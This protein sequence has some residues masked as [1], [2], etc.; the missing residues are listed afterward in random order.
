MELTHKI[1]SFF[2]LD[3]LRNT[4]KVVNYKERKK[5][6]SPFQG[7]GLKELSVR[8]VPCFNVHRTCELYFGEVHTEL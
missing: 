5:N 8:L 2:P 3:R 4:L 6:S 1:L 7:A